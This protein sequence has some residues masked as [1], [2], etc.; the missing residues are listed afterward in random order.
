MEICVDL[1]GRRTKQKY[2]L[3]LFACLFVFLTQQF[4]REFFSLWLSIAATKHHDQSNVE[5]KGFSGFHFTGLFIV[6]GNQ[7]RNSNREG[8]WS[9]ELLQRPWRALLTGLFPR[10]CLA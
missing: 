2:D 1:R 5:R 3:L 8:I 10:A 9:Q 4:E 6:E 7:G